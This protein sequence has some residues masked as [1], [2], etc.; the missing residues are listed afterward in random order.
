MLR[1]TK[2]MT[3][4]K[5]HEA[6]MTYD[7]LDRYMVELCLHGWSRIYAAGAKNSEKG[8]VTTLRFRVPLKFGPRLHPFHFLNSSHW[9]R[10]KKP[11]SK[12]SF[13]YWVYST[14]QG[15]WPYWPQ[16]YNISTLTQKLHQRC[17]YLDEDKTQVLMLKSKLH[18]LSLGDITSLQP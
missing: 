3:N 7:D 16:G 2:H 10:R 5:L 9:K 4:N 17:A 11:W 14:L 8:D 6:L 18:R 1:I 15:I 12:R 13:L